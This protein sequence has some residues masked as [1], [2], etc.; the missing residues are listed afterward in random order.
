MSEPVNEGVEQKDDA[1][2][3]LDLTRKLKSLKLPEQTI[4]GLDEYLKDRRKALLR[5]R[6][7]EIRKWGRR[8]LERE[9]LDVA[10]VDDPSRALYTAKTLE[11]HVIVMEAGFAQAGGEPL[12]L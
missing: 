4:P 1:A 2:S 9:N 7:N 10:I 11:P 8:W 3:G 6:D 12:D 5:C